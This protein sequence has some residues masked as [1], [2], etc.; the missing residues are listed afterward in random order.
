MAEDEEGFLVPRK[1]DQ[2]V[3]RVF[4]YS[5]EPC[6]VTLPDPRVHLRVIAHGAKMASNVSCPHDF[7]M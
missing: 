5:D 2:D 3:P 1:V 7:A 4:S 6:G